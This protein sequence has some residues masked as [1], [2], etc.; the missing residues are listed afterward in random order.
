MKPQTRANFFSGF[1][2]SRT[3]A[4]HG[5]ATMCEGAAI[6]ALAKCRVSL[7]TTCCNS[8]NHWLTSSGGP[9]LRRSRLFQLRARE[10]GG[11]LM[12]SPAAWGR[13][14][15][16]S[17]LWSP[18]CQQR[19]DIGSRLEILSELTLSQ[20]CPRRNWLI[21]RHLYPLAVVVRPEVEIVAFFFILNTLKAFSLHR[22]PEV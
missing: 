21:H 11:W 5:P 6:S 19:V 15:T 7:I 4:C 22:A 1:I 8:E 18:L 9:W 16:E 20:H 14:S 13:Q 10:R 2:L 3:A 12:P 17:S